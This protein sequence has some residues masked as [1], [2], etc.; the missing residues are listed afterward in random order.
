MIL[1]QEILTQ[2]SFEPIIYHSTFG[3]SAITA[4]LVAAGVGAAATVGGSAIA[5]NQQKQAAKGARREAKRLQGDIARLEEKRNRENPIINPYAGAEDLSDMIQ[6]LSGMLSNP[7]ENLGVATQAAEIQMEE[8]DIALANTLD[9]LASTGAS[10]GGATA[11]AQAA[12]RSKQGVAA[13]IEAQEAQNEKLRAQGEAAL[14]QQKMA[15]AT[16]VQQGLFGEATRQQ[17]IDAEGKMFMYR[18]KD[19]R[20]LE[21]LDRKQAQLTGQQ[22]VQAQRSADA[23]SIM[24]AGIKAGGQIIGSTVSSLAG[25]TT[26]GNSNNFNAEQAYLNSITNQAIIDAEQMDLEEL[27]QDILN[28]EQ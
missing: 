13:S 1:I 27:E 4:T 7:F 9:L 28:F 8:T 26:K 2:I 15:E 14:N 12:A 10:A 19:N 16:R 6:D 5:A 24:G 11:L 20:Y 22:Q 25:N 3:M 18:E 21:Q 17:Q 23:A